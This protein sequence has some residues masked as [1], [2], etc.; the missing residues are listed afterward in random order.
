MT[1]KAACTPLTY[2][3]ANA[4]FFPPFSLDTSHVK[5]SE[6][7]SDVENS[8]LAIK[9]TSASKHHERPMNHGMA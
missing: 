7:G 2:K 8:R 4:N 1:P 6:S 5:E 9:V 3:H